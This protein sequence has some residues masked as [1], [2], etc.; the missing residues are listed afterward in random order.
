MHRGIETLL[1]DGVAGGDVRDDVPVSLLAEMVSGAYVE[2]LVS[3]L[4]VKDY[5]LTERLQ[6]TAEVL[7]SALAPQGAKPKS[8]SAKPRA[9]TPRVSGR[10]RAPKR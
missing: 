3:W 6:M 10:Q 5:A 9:R 4:V 2:V 8:L 7:G 1:G